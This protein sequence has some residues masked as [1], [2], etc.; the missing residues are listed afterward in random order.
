MKRTTNGTMKRSIVRRMVASAV[1][2][3]DL[4]SGSTYAECG[5]AYAEALLDFA[6]VSAGEDENVRETPMKGFPAF[7]PIFMMALPKKARMSR[8]FSV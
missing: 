6:V 3:L 1:P 4:A 7:S 8:C 5:N 2:A